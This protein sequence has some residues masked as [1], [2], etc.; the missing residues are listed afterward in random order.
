M[1]SSVTSAMLEQ[2]TFKL[3]T[4][5]KWVTE[6]SHYVSNEDLGKIRIY[7]SRFGLFTSINE[8]GEKLVTGPT[9]ESIATMTYWHLKWNRDGY[10]GLSSVSYDSVVEGKL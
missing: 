10:D 4:F 3:H 2:T 5:D 7:K 9:Q 1:R 6:W 8:N